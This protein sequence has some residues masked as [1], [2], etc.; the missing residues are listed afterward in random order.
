MQTHEPLLSIRIEGKAIGPGRIG[1]D[2]LLRLLK[3]MNKALL[4]CG[5]V[6]E[7][8]ASSLRRGPKRKSL[9]DEIALDLVKLNHA[10]VITGW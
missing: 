9:K 8:G 6:L 7:G 5:Q 2:I 1:I 4:R 3:C 10:C